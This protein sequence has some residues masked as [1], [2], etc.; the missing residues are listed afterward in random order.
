V[1]L[2]IAFFRPG[3]LGLVSNGISFDQYMAMSMSNYIVK[4]ITAV[5]L[6][7]LIYAGHALIDR[8]LG[9]ESQH[10]IDQAAKDSLSE[11]S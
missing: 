9:H 11:S 10:L 8:M 5:A 1:I 6:T 2:G 3:V 7:P 4:L